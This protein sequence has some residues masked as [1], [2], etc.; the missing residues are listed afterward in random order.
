M[1]QATEHYKRSFAGSVGSGMKSIFGGEG[2]RYYILEHKVSSKYHKAGESQKIIV[3]Q[4][5]LGRASQCQVRFDEKFETVSRRHAAIVRD[6]D[7]WK[8]IQLSQTNTTYLNGRPVDK[9]WYLQS[10][11]EIQLST[12]GPKLGFIVPQGEKGLVKSIGMTARLNLFRQQALR[13]YKQAMA[14]IACVLVLCCGIGGYIIYEQGKQLATL[15]DNYATAQKKLDE[16]T[17]TNNELASIVSKQEEENRRRDS[18]IEVWKR[19]ATVPPA[20]SVTKFI[21]QVKPSVYYIVTKVYIRIGD[22]KNLTRS[23]C[24]TGFLLNDGR[25]VTARHCVESWLYGDSKTNILSE[26]YSNVKVWSEI[27]AYGINGDS[28]ELESD[29]FVID[30]RKD[31]ILNLGED[32]DGYQQRYRLVYHSKTSEGEYGTAEMGGNDWAYARINKRGTIVPSGELSV[33]LKA[34][35]EV[36]VLGFPAAL[37][38][39]DGKNCVEPI[40]NKMSVARDGLNKQRCIMVSQG[41]AH[42]NSGGPVF[43]VKNNAIYAIAIVSRLEVATQQTNEEGVIVQQQQQYDQ[44]VP[45][46]NIQ[47]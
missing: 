30:R 18:L 9:E 22:E 25:F 36:H 11:D 29:D 5:E 33:S 16:Q 24:G 31:V 28:F 6:G 15:N 12:N 23:S 37:G 46:K 13:P 7:N 26:T 32:E 17:K 8:L 2:R 27:K 1:S 45:I 40:Y 21:E 14:T 10:G 47:Q 3:D 19:R 35:D 4:I 34:G 20:F 42:G 38:V 44:L 41:V 43:V 39:M